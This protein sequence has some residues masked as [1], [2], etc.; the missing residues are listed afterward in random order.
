MQS[1][2]DADMSRL[3]AEIQTASAR[4]AS[5]DSLQQ[6]V[7]ALLS[8]NLTY[9]HW[10]GFY[11]IDPRD[12]AML[13]LGPFV[14]APTPHV[15]I[16]VSE[17]I[18]GAA[19]STGQSLVVDDVHADPRY[20]SCSIETRSEIVIPIRARG[21]VIGEIDIDSHVPA[22]FTGKDQE[23]LERV[24]LIIGTYVERVDSS[25]E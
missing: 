15:R 16:P 10:T 24:A 6:A 25:F 20:L 23:F 22:A 12:A 8:R 7:V 2:S 21:K 19:V 9:Y 5:L 13:I 1:I 3:L 14:G 18:C 17:G 11:M 4:A